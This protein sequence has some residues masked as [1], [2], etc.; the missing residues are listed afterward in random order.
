MIQQIN[1]ELPTNNN[2]NKDC[3]LL[4]CDETNFNLMVK[5]YKSMA[6]ISYPSSWIE[7]NDQL[8]CPI[9]YSSSLNNAIS[10]AGERILKYI[11][12]NQFKSNCLDFDKNKYL[13]YD[14]TGWNTG[15]GATTNGG[16]LKYFS[17]ALMSNRTFILIGSWDWSL[18]T[19]HCQLLNRTG[20]DCYFFANEISNIKM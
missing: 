19:K 20:F 4:F 6:A 1:N 3:D 14:T 16:I 15:L 10:S 11:Y 13:F 12:D 2:G 5:Y 17:R 7:L 8:F 9:K 18:N